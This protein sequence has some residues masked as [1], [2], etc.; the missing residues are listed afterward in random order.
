MG[1][2]EALC[3]E[4]SAI[5]SEGLIF[6]D[7]RRDMSVLCLFMINIVNSVNDWIRKQL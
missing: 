4:T 6:T 2:Q 3:P 7:L 1:L 5:A